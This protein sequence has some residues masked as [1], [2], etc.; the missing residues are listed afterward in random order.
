MTSLS[1]HFDA[2]ETRDAAQRERE[3]MDALPALVA[4]ARS[5]PGWA[6]RL[7]GVTPEDIDSRL[8]LSQ[9]PVTRKSELKA[10][11]QAGLPFGQLNATPAGKLRRICMSP[12]PIYDP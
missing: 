2:L 10:M 3:L 7:Q 4:R 11:Q 8:A 12:G 1:P 5:A 9:L 6:S